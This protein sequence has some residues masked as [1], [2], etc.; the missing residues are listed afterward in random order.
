MFASCVLRLPPG[1]SHLR[2]LCSKTGHARANTNTIIPITLAHTSNETAPSVSSARLS[3]HGL[4]SRSNIVALTTW[5]VVVVVW[6]GAVYCVI[7]THWLAM[8]LR[9][10]ADDSIQ[11][12]NADAAPVA[13][14]L[15]T[16]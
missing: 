11:P 16:S 13:L 10:A 8:I 3:D 9:A 2:P 1:P 12:M 7:G 4:R 14:P 6:V 15:V 5:S